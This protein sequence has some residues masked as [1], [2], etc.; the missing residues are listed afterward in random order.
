MPT[1]GFKAIKMASSLI[2]V[3]SERR[4]YFSAGYSV[5]QT[6]VLGRLPAAE[7]RKEAAAG[8]GQL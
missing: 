3:I 7:T 1:G 6:S 5:H 8:E 4:K 2:T